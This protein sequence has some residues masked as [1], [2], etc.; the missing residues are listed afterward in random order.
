MFGS[1]N[2]GSKKIGGPRTFWVQKN[3]GPKNVAFKKNMALAWK[4]YFSGRM[5]GWQDGRMAGRTTAIIRLLSPAGA[6]AWAE[7]GKKLSLSAI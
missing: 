4:L 6:W 7:L 2:V 5:A 1:K 3:F